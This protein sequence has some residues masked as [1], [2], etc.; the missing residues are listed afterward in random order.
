L[1]DHQSL[2]KAGLKVTLPRLKILKL[3]EKASD[4]HLSAEAIYRDLL[5]S[6]EDVG[7]ATVYR[8]LTQFEQAGIVVRHHFEGDMSVFEL[9]QGE[10]HDHLV[11][12]HCGYVEEFM[13]S[14]IEQRQHE[15]AKK[16]GFQMMDHS[17]TIYG[18]CK[19]CQ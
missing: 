15:V 8:V 12:T 7:L 17:L 3:L 5:E 19:T 11:C 9:D 1:P 2:K 6:G 13:D 4:H 18:F 16:A 14:V 10:H